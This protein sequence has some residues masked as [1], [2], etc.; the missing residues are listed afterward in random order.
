VRPGGVAAENTNLVGTSNTNAG[1][2][3]LIGYTFPFNSQFS[4]A[5]QADA[6]TGSAHPNRACNNL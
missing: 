3:G 4:L 6:G 5:I 1:I 2:N